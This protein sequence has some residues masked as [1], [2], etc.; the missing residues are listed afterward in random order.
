MMPFRSSRTLLRRAV[1]GGALAALLLPAPAAAQP[2]PQDRA[3]AWFFGFAMGGG[4]ATFTVEGFDSDRE[5]S[6]TGALRGGYAFTDQ[7]GLGL[8]TSSWVRSEED[9][10]VTMSMAA[11]SL[12]AY[13]AAGLVL[14]GGVGAGAATVEVERPGPNLE[15]D[16]RGFGISVG[17]QYE[18]RV[19]RT[20]ALGPQA[21]FVWMT[22]DSVDAN[23]FHGGIS[24]NWYFVPR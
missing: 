5:G 16:E 22:L 24:V 23:Y 19:T 11:V 17:G 6:F 14:R 1:M 2:W 15:A 20:F 18:F 13:P 8:E 9:V 7:L 3:Q 21:D 4:S 10:T 12:Y